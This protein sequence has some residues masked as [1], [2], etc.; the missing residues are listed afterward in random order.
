M[1]VNPPRLAMWLLS[2]RLPDT[3]RDFVLGDLEEEFHARSRTST[4]DAR[5]WFWRQALRCAIAPPPVR[6]YSTGPQDSPGDSMLRTLIADFRYGIRILTRTPAF[7][8]AVVGVLALGL[9]AN[10]AMFSIV[11]AVLLRSLPF[12]E[13]ERIVRLF[14]EPPQAAFPGI[15]RFSVSA[16]NYYDWKRTAHAFDGMAV[17]RFR[18]FT[19][20][21]GG[22]AR[23]VV[24][25]AVDPDFFEVVRA[26]PSLGRTFR[27]EEDSPARGHVAILSDGF[28]RSHFGGAAD[29]VGRTL[30]LD[31]D[32]YTVVGVMPARFTVR[33]WDLTVRELWVPLAY[34]NEQRA[35][36]ENHNAQVIARL[37]P[38]VDMRRAQSEMDLISSRLERE[39]PQANAGWGATVVPLQE[40]IVGEIRTTLLMLL[41]AV[42]LVLLIACANVGNLILARAFGRRKEMAIRAALGAGRA[43][44]FQQLF[45]EALLLALA[46]GAAGLLF[47]RLILTAAAALLADQIP[48]ADE[49]A[50][51]VRVVLFVIAASLA[52]GILAGAVPALRASKTDLN[53][54][55]KEGGRND[56]AVG[57]RTRR[58]LII[59]EVSLS[60]VLLMGAGVMFRT[61]VALR[62]VDTGYNPHDV[63]TLQVTLPETRYKTPSQKTA[64]FSAALQRM[65]ALPGVQSAAAIDTLPSQG[66]SVQPVV[67]EGT[68]ELSPRDQPTVAVRQV[69]PEYLRTMQVPLR[70]GRD[71]AD[72]D[73][74]ALL[75]SASAA[76]LLW[77]EKDPIGTRVTL[78]LMSRTLM[79]EVVGIVG[80]VKLGDLSE[81]PVPTVYMYSHQNPSPGMALVLR[82]SVPPLTLA[83][84]ATGAVRALDPGQ[85][86]EDI[87]TMDAVLE[88]T[89]TSQRFSV[90]LLGGFACAA[91]SLASVGI[92][93]VLS[94]IVRGRSREIGIR[95]ALGARTADV[96]RLVV[97]EGMAPALIGI[98]IGIVAALMSAPV[99]KKLVFGVNAS[100][101]FTLFGVAAILAFVALA[102]SLVPAYR[103]SRLDPLDVLRAG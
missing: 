16:A 89:L 18:Q 58:L 5:R 56:A 51:D 97:F 46:G 2:H 32:V 86:V 40:V 34:T 30:T 29:V 96:V 38:G 13:P 75:V 11:N 73:Q 48:R 43:R 3:W 91:L 81:A 72:A 54:A 22:E 69:S 71:V 61:L 90:L 8:L 19:L 39:Y 10:T 68:A 87:L 84:P 76:R 24:A 99:L 88:Q 9:G 60:L 52:A 21:G 66:G 7:T 63:L 80:D 100:D 55:L 93:S 20:S 45:I 26:Q 14:H 53:G 41:G 95:T 98:A 44:V 83:R 50:I 28:W 92:Y 1:K 57:L 37:K 77:G 78:P 25:G 82:T 4:P 17:Y 70:R 102:A 62:S 79:R 59:C 23:S 12:Q 15:H 27:P 31:G 49:I 35:V 103:A 101:P 6:W 64:F 65:R 36:R 85:P 74:E 94:Y 42:A 67:V 47:A 33:S